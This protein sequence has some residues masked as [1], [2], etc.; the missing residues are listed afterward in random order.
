[1]PSYKALHAVFLLTLLIQSSLA[2]PFEG[3]DSQPTKIEFEKRDDYVYGLRIAPDG[4]HPPVTSPEERR[5]IQKRSNSALGGLAACAI[6]AQPEWPHKQLT[7]AQSDACT[8]TSN[9]AKRGGVLGAPT[10]ITSSDGKYDLQS[11][12]STD[13][14]ILKYFLFRADFELEADKLCTTA[15]SYVDPSDNDNTKLVPVS[16]GIWGA[17]DEKVLA[18]RKTAQ[19]IWHTS[20]QRLDIYT[21]VVNLGMDNTAD[22]KKEAYSLCLDA[23]SYLGETCLVGISGTISSLHPTFQHE[24]QKPGTVTFRTKEGK[25]AIAFDFS[26]YDP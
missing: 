19:T 1:M 23:V 12:C 25:D 26:L 5:D 24:S 17:E 10:E 20:N 4:E 15:L 18:R 6:K 7:K 11:I 3:Q 22:A 8:Q 9:K 13:N 21:G 16:F 14:S 2:V